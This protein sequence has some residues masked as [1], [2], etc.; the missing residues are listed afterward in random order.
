[1]SINPENNNSQVLR[2][3]TIYKSHI[4][5]IHKISILYQANPIIGRTH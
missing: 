2:M 5:F 3:N 1:M 4:A